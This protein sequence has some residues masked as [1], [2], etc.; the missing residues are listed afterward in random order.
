MGDRRT[1]LADRHINAD[2]VAAFLV[3]D[4][5]D[6]DSGLAGLAIADDQLAL[7]AADGDH[8]VHGLNAGLHGLFYRLPGNHAGRQAL[9]RI[10]LR[11]QDRAFT[12]DGLTQ[13]IHD[14]T[15]ERLAHRHFGDATG[16]LH[17]IALFDH[18]GFTEKG[19]A[20]VILFEVQRDAE[21]PVGKFQQLA[22]GNFVQTVNARNTVAG[23]KDGADLLDLDRFLVVPNL[24]F[25]DS[26]NL[27]CPYF[28]GSLLSI[29]A[30]CAVSSFPVVSAH[31]R[32]RSC[33]PIRL[34]GRR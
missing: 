31:C 25:D 26:A 6:G 8:G 27:R 23:G 24:L 16:A 32:H 22:G 34:T 15:D 3:D 29:R 4:R 1:L 2:D 19:G 13:G 28:H 12:V 11:G 18:V 17:R 7:A 21:N 9:D 20:D 14:A 30:R 10:E 33:L 5:V